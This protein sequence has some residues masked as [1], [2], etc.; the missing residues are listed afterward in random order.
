MCLRCDGDRGAGD[1]ADRDAVD[2]GSRADGLL[3]CV[4]ACGF[5]DMFVDAGARVSAFGCARTYVC[6]CV[7]HSVITSRL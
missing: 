6:V 1:V 7:Y 4:V 3:F 2:D 5:E